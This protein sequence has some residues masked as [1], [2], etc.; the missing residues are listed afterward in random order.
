MAERAIGFRGADARNLVVV[1]DCHYP[2]CVPK[3]TI[4]NV[5]GETDHVWTIGELIVAA[6]EQTDAPP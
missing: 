6:L 4:P 2:R 3:G 1:H 5:F